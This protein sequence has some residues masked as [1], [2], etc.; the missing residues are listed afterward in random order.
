MANEIVINMAKLR[1]M[2]FFPNTLLPLRFLLRNLRIVLLKANMAKY[3]L[4]PLET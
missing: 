4:S 1:L 2:K 3:Q